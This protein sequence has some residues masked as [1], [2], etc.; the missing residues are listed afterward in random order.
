MPAGLIT[1]LLLLLVLVLQG[2]CVIHKIFDVK[3]DAF[4]PSCNYC[5]DYFWRYTFYLP[6]F[7]GQSTQ[8]IYN[9]P[10]QFTGCGGN[11]VWDLNEVQFLNDWG[12]YKWVCLDNIALV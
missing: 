11:A 10:A 7:A 8:N 9:S 6:Y 12:N 4:E 3:P 2:Q 5:G 1:P